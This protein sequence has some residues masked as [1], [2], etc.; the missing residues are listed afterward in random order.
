MSVSASESTV[1]AMGR[2]WR[3]VVGP[4]RGSTLRAGGRALGLLARAR[5]RRPPQ[6]HGPPHPGDPRERGRPAPERPRRRLLRRLACRVLWTR[7]PAAVEPGARVPLR[8][9]RLVARRPP[10]RARCGA[11]ALLPPAPDRRGGGGDDD[12][13]GAV[14]APAA[15]PRVPRP[16]PVPGPRP[17]HRARGAARSRSSGRATSASTPSRRS[18]SGA[19]GAASSTS[20]RP[21][22]SGR[23]GRNSSATRSSRCASSIRPASAPSSPSRSSP[24]CRWS[25]SARGPPVLTAYL[26]GD[27]LVVLEDPALLDAPPD[28]AP[29]AEPL[30]AL[31]A[32]FQRLELP[33]LAGPTSAGTRVTMGTRSVGGFR[34]QFKEMAA[35]IR[36][37]RGEGFAVRLVV[38]D[39]RQA[40]RLRR[41]LSEHELEAWPGRDALELG[42]ARRG[43]RR[44][45]GGL[46]APRARSGRPLRAGSLRRAA[47]AAPPAGVPAGRRPSPPS[48]TWR[49]MTSSSTRCTAS[50]ATTA[51]A[52]SRRTGAMP[53]SS[54]SN[55]P[56][57]AGSTCP[58]SGWT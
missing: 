5:A 34:G 47:A 26:P 50:P 35:E 29:S 21:P 3:A 25:G 27:A 7:R 33:L 57:A 39:E 14:A 36:G 24:C 1:V 23:C 2:V 46:S 12:P 19:C 54:C 28:D 52:R 6:G 44:V 56:T 4:R 38:D 13:G 10:S 20:S 37:W 45:R 32:D 48:P 31:L 17:E 43:R 30:A 22:T 55:T 51:S 53:I 18:G 41:M 11:R 15:A 40:E 16:D 8:A 42:G 49:P 58:W 9:A